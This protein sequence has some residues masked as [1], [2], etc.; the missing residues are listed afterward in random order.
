LLAL[1]YFGSVVVL[2]G[3]IGQFTGE[4][5][6]AVIVISTLAIVV[7]FN[8]LRTRIQD[9]IDRRFYRQKYDAER[10]LEEFAATARDEVELEKLTTAL[11]SVV[12]ETVQ[13]DQISLWLKHGR[14]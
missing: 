2:Q 5:S 3:L 11:L 10:A 1:V 7:L 12:E 14:Q 8:P 6:P 4:Q 9:F 13:P